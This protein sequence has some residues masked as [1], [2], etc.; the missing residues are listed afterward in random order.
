MAS[1]FLNNA[2]AEA[3]QIKSAALASAKISLEEAFQPTLQRM[4]SSK[5]SEEEGEEDDFG[6]E[7]DINVDVNYGD[8]GGEEQ[9]FAPEGEEGGQGF[10]SFE[11]EEPAPEEEDRE[12][13]LE[14]LIRELDGEEDEE[15]SSIIYGEDCEDDMYSEGFEDEVMSDNPGTDDDELSEALNA[16]FEEEGLGDD[17]DMGPNK[18][19]GAVYTDSLPAGPQFLEARK[20]RAEN[21]KLK[22]ERNEAFQAVTIL[23]KTLNEV[24]LLNAK[25]MFTTKTFKQFA[26]NESQQSRILDSFDRANNVRE[27]KLVYTT[28]CESFNKK[29]IS[30]TR[31][32]EG[33]AS[34]S[35]RSVNPVKRPNPNQQIISEAFVKKM[36]RLANTNRFEDED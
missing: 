20:L 5:L 29:P 15:D 6:G 19:D 17:L 25:L 4:I 3:K 8:E 23:K 1:N 12:R 2:I 27:V 26:L 21:K 31:V 16:L 22:K 7:E 33:F 10:G 11:D 30:K 24:N 14:S 32:Q 18:E 36:Q 34:K 28:I 13:E 9:D 35:T